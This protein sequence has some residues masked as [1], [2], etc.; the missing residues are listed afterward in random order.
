MYALP[1]DSFSSLAPAAATYHS[2]AMKLLSH[3]RTLS[4][5]PLLPQ[6]QESTSVLPSF[7]PTR[8]I[9][10]RLRRR[11]VALLV[12][13]A[14]SF[15]LAVVHLATSTTPMTRPQT[16]ADTNTPL[17]VDETTT[18][19]TSVESTAPPKSFNN[20]T[21]PSYSPLVL[22]P[23]TQ[24]FRENL[25]SDKKYITSWYGAGWSACLYKLSLWAYTHYLRI[26]SDND[27]ITMMN[28]IYLAKITDRIPIIPTFTPSWHIG[29]DAP[30]IAFGEIFDVRR[31]ANETGVEMLEWRDV[32][33]PRSEEV[34]ELGC[35]SVWQ[36]VQKDEN[37]PRDSDAPKW[38]KLGACTIY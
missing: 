23:P 9:T 18:N 38:L 33:D 19:Y 28:L 13:G 27:V 6:K 29:G 20:A 25:R 8:V 22:G 1:F 5:T 4:S 30:G 14:L 16:Y 24:R 26:F 2:S 35:W 36:A 11:H 34:E 37:H 7:P 10:Y 31:F 15:G 32:K 12:I 21:A 17:A 3:I